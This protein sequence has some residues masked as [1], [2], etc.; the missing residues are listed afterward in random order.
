MTAV[1][2]VFGLVSRY[3]GGSEN[4]ARELSLQLASHG[5]RHVV[6]FLEPPPDDVLRYL[7]L[8]NT[9]VEVLEH[10]DAACPSRATLRKLS[11]ILQTH[12]AK[13]LHLHL[14]GFVGPYPWLAKWRSVRRIFFTNHMSQPEGFVPR[15]SPFW[16]RL[17]VRVINWPLSAVVCVSDYNY[18]CTTA[19]DLL[20]PERIKRIYNG[21]DFA[22]VSEN[23]AERSRSFRLQ[24]GIPNDRTLI[25]QVSWI[26]REKGVDD[27]L[28]A[29]RLVL[30][31]NQNCHFVFAGEGADRSSFMKKAES[32]GIAGHVTWTGLVHDPFAAGLYDAADIVCQPS[33]WE[34][35]FGQVI[36]EAMACGK[37]VVGTRVGGIPEVIEDG[38]SGFI[39]ER[40]DVT[41]LAASILKLVDDPVLRRRFGETGRDIA[42]TKFDLKLILR[43]IV[44][45]YAVGS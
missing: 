19:L 43:E 13:I 20:P 29:A 17:L 25:A 14:V 44:S 22:R 7:E 30:A 35:A 40:G 15:R 5:W 41:A 16:K 1:V 8:P 12:N 9:S 38:K 45:L 23:P 24:Y 39:V 31:E 11:R 34:E 36:A 33:R 42:R 32:A 28:E 21:V 2:T 3:I 27:H 6:C 18:R 10:S 26:I 37:P 4:Y